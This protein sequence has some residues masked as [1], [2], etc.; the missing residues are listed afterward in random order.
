MGPAATSIAAGM[1]E[2]GFHRCPEAG[3]L[4]RALSQQLTRTFDHPMTSGESPCASSRGV[5]LESESA[6]GC[7]L[8]FQANSVGNT[9]HGHPVLYMKM[10]GSRD[11]Q[12]ML[13]VPSILWRAGEDSFAG[14]AAFGEVPLPC[15]QQECKELTRLILENDS[16]HF[17]L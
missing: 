10:L 15:N 16:G 11:S 4:G 14:T 6:R 2:P 5:Q 12:R 8:H 1:S 7:H 3:Q 9:G 13:E 17:D